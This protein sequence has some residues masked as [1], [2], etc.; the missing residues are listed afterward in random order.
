MDPYH[1]TGLNHSDVGTD[2]PDTIIHLI[3]KNTKRI[4]RYCVKLEFVPDQQVLW[5]G[6]TS[7]PSFG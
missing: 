1:Y 5:A 4:S 6:I 7:P 3:Q 2:I